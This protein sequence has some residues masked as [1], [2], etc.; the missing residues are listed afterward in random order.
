MR[1]PWKRMALALVV[2]LLLGAGA[3]ILALHPGLFHHPPW[4][5]EAHRE[6]WLLDHFTRQLDLTPEQRTQV[7]AIL[8]DKREKIHSLEG[9]LQPR[10]QEIRQAA[11][12]EIRKILTPEQQAKFDAMAEKRRDRRFH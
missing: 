9:E 10:F 11:R 8:E 1:A 7:A 6:A 3:A 12:E 2:G 4:W 5:S